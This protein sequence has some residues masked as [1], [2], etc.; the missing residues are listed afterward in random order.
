MNFTKQRVL[1]AVARYPGLTTPELA[2]HIPEVKPQTLASA[3]C[4]AR[5]RGLVAFTE[6]R[7]FTNRPT[8]RHYPKG[9]TPSTHL[10]ENRQAPLALPEPP[11]ALS[12]DSMADQLVAVVL[13]PLMSLVENKLKAELP[14]R[15]EALVAS[16][17]PAPPKPK[18]LKVCIVGLLP[19]QAGFIS[20]EFGDVF[21]L[22]FW[23]DDDPKRLRAYAKGCDVLYGMADFISHSHHDLVAA[24]G[25]K[26]IP[27]HGGMTSLRDVLTKRYV[28]DT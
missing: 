22:S 20:Q 24:G 14:R 27:V 13:G 1:D 25:G 18:K 11:P 2:R 12:L 3:L 9:G 15:M 23:K 28:E 19:Q 4:Y 10:T 7:S 21:D 16:A 17:L 8:Y 6:F 5:K 26:L